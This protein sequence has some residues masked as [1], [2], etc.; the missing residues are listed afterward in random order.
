MDE[1]MNMYSVGPARS[2][3]DWAALR[4]EFRVKLELLDMDAL[5]VMYGLSRT[6]GYQDDDFVQ[7]AE[8]YL[9]TLPDPIRARF[10]LAY[11]LGSNFW[12]AYDLW[13]ADYMQPDKPG[14]MGKL[15]DEL[16]DTIMAW[17]VEGLS[18]YSDIPEVMDS[19][20]FL[21]SRVGNY[22]T[23]LEEEDIPILEAAA[24]KEISIENSEGGK[25][26]IQLF[27]EFF[28]QA[29]QKE[30]DEDDSSDD[31]RLPI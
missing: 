9:A 12:D 26:I 31:S 3:F 13:S 23:L 24:R 27:T 6:V 15:M 10:D 28:N 4:D 8:D 16:R 7:K 22:D 14:Y 20:Y 11:L 18:V 19:A 29:R 21:V 5:A 2:I 1:D 25:K 17:L 30:K